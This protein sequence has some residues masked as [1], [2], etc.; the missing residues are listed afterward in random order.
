VQ[1]GDAL[2]ALEKE[3]E[4]AARQEALER[5][6][7]AQARLANLAATRRPPEL[8]ASQAQIDQADAVRKYLAQQS[9][10]YT[11]L[12]RAGFIS[13]ARLDELL[14]LLDRQAAEVAERAAQARLAHQSIGRDQELAPARADIDAARAVLAQA[15]WKLDQKAQRAPAAGLHDPARLAVGGPHHPREPRFRRPHVWRAPAAGGGR[16]VA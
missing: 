16:R 8:A 5:T 6:R 11:E 13:R 15:Q 2:F 4:T 12:E 7:S 3:N 9:A 14:S 1:A 10:R